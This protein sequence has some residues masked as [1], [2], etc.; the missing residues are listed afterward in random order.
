MVLREKFPEIKLVL[1]SKKDIPPEMD[2]IRPWAVLKKPFVER[3]LFSLFRSSNETIASDPEYIDLHIPEV[4]QENAVNHL[5]DKKWVRQTI[6]SALEKLDVQEAM[7]YS[8]EGLI[9]Q[10]GELVQETID[11]CTRILREAWKDHKGTEIILPVHLDSTNKNH[12]IHSNFLA[13]GLLLAL[14][15]DGDTSLKVIRS[16]TRYLT[17]LLKNPQLAVDGNLML[18]ERAGESESQQ[19][20]LDDFNNQTRFDE[21]GEQPRFPGSTKRPGGKSV[22]G[23]SKI[24]G[25]VN[26]SEETNSDILFQANGSN[27]QGINQASSEKGLI[28]SP[29]QGKQSY[30]MSLINPNM[31]DVYFACALVPRV[32]IPIPGI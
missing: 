19:A 25:R 4:R 27:A 18:P 15:Y 28:K 32:K 31:A 1:I 21:N 3:E 12:I 9:A 26:P 2:E 17:R 29:A 30:S 6:E 23:D 13:V 16:Q 5:E 7:V 22:F 24:N 11:E 20:A 10:S 14:A 8:K